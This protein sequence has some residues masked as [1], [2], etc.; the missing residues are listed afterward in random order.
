MKEHYFVVLELPGGKELKFEDEKRSPKN[1]WAKTANV[2]SQGKA[3]IISKRQ[4]TGISEDLRRH[5]VHNNRFT[6]YVLAHMHLA[7]EE[8]K[9]EKVIFMN[10]AE[11]LNSPTHETVIDTADNFQLVTIES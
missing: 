8:C 7:K 9:N 1:F 4:D 5:L 6:T 10:V 11:W 2:I 3:K